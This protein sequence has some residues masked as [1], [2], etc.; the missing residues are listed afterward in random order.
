MAAPSLTA[1][2][3]RA[4]MTVLRD[5]LTKVVETCVDQNPHL[6]AQAVMAALG[7]MLAQFC[8]SQV[9]P[10]YTLRFLDHLKEAVLSSSTPMN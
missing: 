8:V 5:E 3:L 4:K 1:E 10:Q 7:E 9:G 2:E 6:P